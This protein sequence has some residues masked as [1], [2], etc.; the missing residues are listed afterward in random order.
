[1]N[2]KN[3]D[4]WLIPGVLIGSLILF[5]G[6]ANIMVHIALRYLSM[7]SYFDFAFIFWLFI[8][9]IGGI[10]LYFSYR[11]YSRH[12]Q[13]MIDDQK[14]VNKA[15]KRAKTLP[16]KYSYYCT[17]CLFQTNKISTKCPKCKIGNLENVI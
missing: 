9:F 13:E 12:H 16:K 10:I 4:K 7:E 5:S 17:A 8:T 1:M 11:S 6:I 2:N 3:K 14:Q 15:E